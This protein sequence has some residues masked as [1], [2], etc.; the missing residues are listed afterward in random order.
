MCRGHEV[1]LFN[2]G[3]LAPELFPAALHLHGHRDG[4]LDCLRGRTFDRVIDTCGYLPRVVR[5]SAELLAGASPHYTVDGGTVIAQFLAARLIDDMTLS[6]IPVVLGGGRRFF[7]GG[8][9]ERRLVLEDCR[10][11]PTGLVQLR[12]S[13]G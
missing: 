4:G 11:W 10:S 1:T 8:E 9:A 13:V 5:A 12:Y 7:A 2:R 3:L 6:V